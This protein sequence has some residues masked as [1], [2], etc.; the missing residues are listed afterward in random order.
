LRD[1]WLGLL[2]GPTLAAQ[3]HRVHMDEPCAAERLA[4]AIFEFGSRHLN[5]TGE[6]V[7]VCIGT[8]RSTGD[9]LGPLIGSHLMEH[10]VSGCT[11]LGTLDNPVH[12][13][14]L[15]DTMLWVSEQFENPLVLAVDAC[16][17]RVESVGLLTVGAGSLKPGAAVNK[18]LPEVGQVYI[19]GVVNVGGF[20][21]FLVLQNTRLSLVWRMAR[22]AAGGIA[23]GVT[24]LLSSRAAAV[25]SIH[26]SYS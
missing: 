5:G 10:A 25:S 22:V 2:S 11:V 6:I 19:T 8:D 9:A 15:A 21:E 16:L 24:A 18:T 14:N 13:T 4:R 17:G 7:L 26:G 12:A 1:G 3:E 23:Q 20:M